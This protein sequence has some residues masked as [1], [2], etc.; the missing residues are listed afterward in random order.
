MSQVEIYAKPG[1]PFCIRA[2]SL[3]NERGIDYEVRDISRSPALRDEMI[4]RGGRTTV[5]Q[6]WIDGIHVGGWDDLSSYDRE[7]RLKSHGGSVNK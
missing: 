5:P 6:I 2:M 4:Q 1:C 3:L 7:G